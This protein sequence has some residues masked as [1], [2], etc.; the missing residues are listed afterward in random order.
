MVHF[1][2]NP[3]RISFLE[4]H[5]KIFILSS[6][7]VLVSCTSSPKPA[8]DKVTLEPKEQDGYSGLEGS[9]SDPRKKELIRFIV[10]LSD[11]NEPFKPE[12][13]DALDQIPASPAVGSFAEAAI[14]VGVL[15]MTLSNKLPSPEMSLETQFK[16][17]GVSLAEALKKNLVI[18]NHKVYRMAA[19]ALAQT[20]NS[21]EFR[22]EVGSIIKSEADKWTDILN[23]PLPAATTTDAAPGTS[24]Q[25]A[26][27]TYSTA[28]FKKRDNLLWE[29]E[30]L[31][32]RGMYKEAI[33]K[34]TT[35][36][37]ADPFY[38]TAKEKIRDFSNKA[39]Q[40]LRQKAAQAFE[41][42][43]PV[44]DPKS[45]TAYLEEAKKY[46]EEAIQDYPQADHISTVK[47]NLAVIS[48]DIERLQK[49]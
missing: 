26:Q 38:P 27:P 30:L 4:P 45:K 7:F 20:N 48:R 1:C 16:K 6:A 18:K 37:E 49:Q 46:L 23:T 29:S 36:N 43:L 15:K 34:V 8:E 39:V 42:A 32:Q 28:E 44:S 11:E 35:I 9:D 21:P 47:E 41:N 40:T 19:Q 3:K 5:L 24:E 12:D 2:F 10:R 33:T 25:T 14:V 31:A 13:K 17:R 22:T